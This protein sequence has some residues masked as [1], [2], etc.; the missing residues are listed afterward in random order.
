VAN[1]RQPDEGIAK[2]SGDRVY[3][4]Q[5]IRQTVTS[6]MGEMSDAAF[7]KTLKRLLQDQRLFKVDRNRYSTVSPKTLS[8]YRPGYSRRARA[9][10]QV[11]Q[12][13]FGS[14]DFVTSESILLNEFLGRPIVD[15]TLFLQVERV[16]NLD[17]YEYLKKTYVGRVLY[18][19]TFPEYFKEWEKD[20]IVI[21]DLVTQA[22]RNEAR[23]H[24]M[25]IEKLLVD[26]VCDRPMAASFDA[27]ETPSIYQ[28]AFETYRVRRGKVMRY[29]ARRGKK[30]VLREYLEQAGIS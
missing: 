18:R 14:L 1:E 24:E 30:E 6:E 27:R 9:L 8:I 25:P 3:T 22:P 12:N 5:D 13:K 11:L 2:L 10:T 23:P 26:I 7:A 17:V 15:N 20:C 16:R 28:K 29:A 4:R 21:V 19:P